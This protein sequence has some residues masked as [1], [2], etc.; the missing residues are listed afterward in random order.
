MGDSG[1][2]L[3]NSVFRL[4]DPTLLTGSG[5]YVDD[6]DCPGATRIVFVRS[7]VA[8]GELRSVDVEAARSMPGVVAVYCAGGDDL[9]LAP[10]QSFPMLS[11]AVN[12]PVFARDRVRFVGDIVAAVVAESGAQAV[13]AAETV[14]VD[15]EPLP[16]VVTQAAALDPAAPLLFPENGSNVCFATSFGSEEDPLE[17]AEVVAEVDMVSQR[18]AGVPMETNGC[19]MVP[20]EPSG[21]ITCWISHQAP[22]SVQPA[23]AAV[24]G[25]E[26]AAVRVVCPWV[27]GGFGPKAAMYVEYLI[28]AAAAR[29]LDRSVRWAST[30]SE[31]MV[32]L[33]QGRDYT[34]TAKLG[35]TRDGRIVGLDASVVASCGAY[36]LLGAVLPMLTQM[37]V[38]GVYDIAKVRFSGTTVV[39]NTTPV[40]AY[41]GAGRPEATQLIERVLDV[42]ADQLGLDPAEIRRRNFIDPAAFPM[43]TVTGGAYD[44]G[45]YA[46][47]LDAAL[48]AAGYEELRA[49]QA[50]RR[51][52]GEPVALGI[53]V[54]TYVEVT[55]PLGL[56]TEY[57]AVEIHDDG[58]ASMAVGTSSHGQGHHTA[59]AMVASDV[60]GI[61]MER[62]RLINSD[63]AAVPRGTGTMGSRSLQT[64]GNAVFAASTVVLER[65]RSI[66]AHQFEASP[67][68]IVTGAGGLHV[69]GVPG[70]SVSWQELAVASRDASLLPEGL[71]PEPLRHE[72]DF[73]GT[74]STFPFGAHVSVVE[75]D[76]ETGKVTMRRHIAVDDCGRILSPLLVRG[77]Q[78]GGI[79]QGAAQALFE[80]V[81]Y[82]DDGNPLTTTLLDYPVPAASELPSFEASNTETDSPLNPLGAKGIGESGTIGSTPA[83]QNA[84]IDALSHLGVTHVDMPCTP[85]RVWSAIEGATA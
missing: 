8:H 64:A 23:L 72:G 6:L 13:D 32:A 9:G 54:S 46:K 45:D 39:T 73:D 53:G 24:L 12:R 27:G 42:A 15:I 1:S 14:V 25:L 21:G 74:G 31:D 65:A 18:L 66:A 83:I 69:A 76:T 81:Q 78:H 75:V 67:Q 47:A 51:A 4:E 19:L 34:M 79:A 84:V 63:T 2:I 41:R 60:L 28:A 55:A 11:E 62:I 16:A 35:L 26:P 61:P 82:D 37:M 10:F 71:E 80:W 29:Q 44:S 40:G 3:G 5:K 50:R 22:H 38:V 68:D 20:G 85:E 52:A 36:P 33:V 56:H 77:Q 70:Q 49:E 58:S 7:S 17:G 57:G 43:T 48:A 30:R 59:F